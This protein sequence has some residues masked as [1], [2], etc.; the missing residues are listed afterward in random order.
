M[1]YRFEEEK[2]N[3]FWHRM[4]VDVGIWKRGRNASKINLPTLLFKR[5]LHRGRKKLDR[6][7]TCIP[8]I[9]VV[10]FLLQVHGNRLV[11]FA[12]RVLWVFDSRGISRG[13][14][15]RPLQ[16]PLH[17][18]LWLRLI[19]LHR[20]RRACYAALRRMSPRR[21]SLC[22]T[23]RKEEENSAFTPALEIIMKF[24]QKMYAHLHVLNDPFLND[25]L[26]GFILHGKFPAV[27]INLQ[28]RTEL[29]CF[30]SFP[31]GF[32]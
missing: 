1:I 10:L 7:S 23:R 20:A 9:F 14:G 30:D 8:P 32:L 22:I 15:L 16:W 6:W 31:D 26:A 25:P 19:R 12:Y 18:R 24:W 27:C 29:F 5:G 11:F 2:E 21:R 13:K 4:I 3:S 28:Y 17:R